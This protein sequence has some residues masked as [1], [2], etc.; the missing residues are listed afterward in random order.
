MPRQEKA[1]SAQ[2]MRADHATLK[3]A[4]FASQ[5]L[6]HAKEQEKSNEHRT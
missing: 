4:E 5:H 2:A 6:A 1:Q 3:L